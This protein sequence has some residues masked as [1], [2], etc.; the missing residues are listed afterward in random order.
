MS[1]TRQLQLRRMDGGQGVEKVSRG[2]DRS[3]QQQ[4]RRPM[5]VERSS[6]SS[7]TE[8][9]GGR[10][11]GRDTSVWMRGGNHSAN[12]KVLCNV[13]PAKDGLGV[14]EDWLSRGVLDMMLAALYSGAHMT[15]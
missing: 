9:L 11:V 1:G 4:E 15:V 13:C 10:G 3:K 2:T 12:R 8:P 7:A 6:V 5:G 14:E